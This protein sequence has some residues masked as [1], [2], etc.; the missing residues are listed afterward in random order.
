[1]W[2]CVCF[3]ESWA[4]QSRDDDDDDDDDDGDGDGDDD[5]DDDDDPRQDVEWFYDHIGH[6]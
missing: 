6:L 1:M 5:D 3:S 2:S 4:E